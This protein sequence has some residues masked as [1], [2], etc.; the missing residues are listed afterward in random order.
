[1]SNSRF[2]LAAYNF[3]KA[4]GKSVDK[5][6][7]AELLQINIEIR[8]VTELMVDGTKAMKSLV[9]T[10]MGFTVPLPVY[11]A[12][13]QGCLSNR[14]GRLGNSIN[15]MI[16]CEECGCSGE[17]MEGALKDPKQEC[18]LPNGQK[19][20]RRYVGDD[21]TGIINVPK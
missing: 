18:R 8:S 17:F 2:Q 21:D 12:R 14:C 13:K 3:A 9:K 20:W 10:K 5:L 4:K 16:V 7:E 11:T 19:I 1:M 6:T 15:G